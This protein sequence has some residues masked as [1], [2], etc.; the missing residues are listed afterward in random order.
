[1]KEQKKTATNKKREKFE[2]DCKERLHEERIMNNGLSAKIIKYDGYYHVDIQFEDGT[3]VY[4]K[5][6]NHFKKGC[7]AH[8]NLQSHVSIN[9]LVCL[10]Y[11]QQLGFRKAETG[12][13]ENIGLGKK[14]L[15]IYNPDFYGYA[16]GIE[17]D[18]Y[19]KKNKNSK[20]IIGGH[21]KEKDL[22]KNKLCYENN[23]LL[24]RI[25]ESHLPKLNSTS[26]DFYIESDTQKS[27][28][29]LTS[30]NDII[31]D[32]E[33]LVNKQF[34]IVVD[35]EQDKDSIYEFIK[36]NYASRHRE[37]RL[38]ERRTMRDGFEAELIDY[39]DSH[40]VVVRFLND[41]TL[42]NAYYSN[43]KKGTI[44]HPNRHK[45]S[46]YLGETKT[47]SC[48]LEATV[49]DY[50]GCRN[51]T[52][53][54]SDGVIV[55]NVNHAHFR[56]GTVGHPNINPGA[57]T[58]KKQNNLNSKEEIYIGMSRTMSN[59]Q[60]AKLIKYK[61]DTHISIQFE[62]G[63]IIEDTRLRN[64]L[65][66]HITNPNHHKYSDR[67]N[68]IRMMQCGM[69]A[70]VTKYINSKNITVRFADGTIVE[71]KTYKD[72]QKGNILNP[73]LKK[74]KIEPEI[75]MQIKMNCGIFATLL[76]YRTSHD[77]DIQFDDG[78]IIKHKRFDKF[79]QGAI[80]NPN[81]K[82]NEYP[83]FIEK[84]KEEQKP[85]HYDE[86]INITSTMNNGLEA[87]VIEYFNS[88]NCTVQFSDG[89]IVKNIAYR[90]F[91][92]GS[93]GHPNINSNTYRKLHKENKKDK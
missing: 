44:Q 40:H 74:D 68:E 76:E 64:F 16:I 4:D 19:V 30:I 18:G 72:F 87:T 36:W 46:K 54:F 53:R 2:A 12:T 20:E 11:F 47:M 45:Y 84:A 10:Y 23:I 6:Y 59:G 8:P 57:H 75:G 65:R 1:M 22:E 56:K 67:F 62:D 60:T 73:Q 5:C 58:L 7:I 82:K 3:I 92:K 17:Y 55:K 50:F 34:H 21:T 38:G 9:E 29:L 85:K 86:R 25:R 80:G 15:D 88:C 13:L 48:G 81:V 61:N 37:E 43:F 49:I 70:T 31:N 83:S 32:F 77:I 39:I 51:C 35:F 33:H 28:S 79:L 89:V 78:T 41:G 91:E 90:N 42:V 27:Q 66:G 14:E 71:N 52:I 26:K 69:E 63:T 93:V 24:Y